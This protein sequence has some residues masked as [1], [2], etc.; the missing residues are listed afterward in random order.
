MK[1]FLKNRKTNVRSIFPPLIYVRGYVWILN[2]YES[3][4][5]LRSGSTICVEYWLP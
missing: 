3:I 2:D 1:I 5:M 4:G